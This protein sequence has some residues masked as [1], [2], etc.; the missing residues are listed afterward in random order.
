MKLV[1][2]YKDELIRLL[3][4]FSIAF[5]SLLITSKNSFLYPLNDW[6][7]AN[8][9]FTTGKAMVR[10]VVPYLD[11]FEQK[12][13]FLYLIYGLGSLIS[14]KSF[15]GV[16]I[17]EVINYT[18][19]LYYCFKTINLFL[20]K[21]YGYLILPVLTCLLTTSY[22]F[23][24]GGG[25]EEFVLSLFGITLYYFFYHFKKEELNYKQLFLAGLSAGLILLVKYTLLGFWFI[26]MAS[27]FFSL[28]K[29]KRIKKA[30][31]ACLVF[32][33]GM[34]LPLICFIIYFALHHA[35]KE[36]IDVYFLFNMTS[37]GDVKTSFFTRITRLL[38]GVLNASFHNGIIIC[39]LFLASFILIFFLDLKKEAKISYIVL[40]LFT[41]LGI[42]F[43]LRFY[44]YYF[45]PLEIFIL[46]SL[47]S[48][49]YLINKKININK[50]KLSYIIISI[51]SLL[52]V[53]EGANYKDMLFLRKDNMFQYQFL[54]N[55]KLDSEAT[56]LNMGYLDC[57]LYTTSGIIPSTYYFQV[58][59]ISYDD[60]P[61]LYLKM[62]EYVKNKKIKYV[63]YFTKKRLE[64]IKIEEKELFLNY[65]LIKEARQKFQGKY[66]N[67][68]LLERI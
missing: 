10:G 56:L 22:A 53:Y 19:F 65:E 61:D 64:E 58:Q 26:F 23:A 16:F 17:L 8:A 39:L 7:D 59:N 43:G 50:Y 45:F 63:I 29:E 41:I 31:L 13:P 67:A 30:F 51:L 36:F 1:E 38:Q 34:F 62:Q 52:L 54:D 2:K 20:K 15:L 14:Y 3:F 66:M 48:I 33:L 12:G 37:Y 5:I 42:Y 9:F 32:L 4:C 27:I 18:I 57:G 47:I 24:H 68:Y 46:I 35:L 21:S 11:L 60:Y 49:C 25:A 55:M 6:V 28:L 40:E 44:R